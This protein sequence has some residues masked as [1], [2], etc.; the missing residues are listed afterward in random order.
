MG[1]LLGG[2][3]NK[4]YGILGVY[5]GVLLF[6]VHVAHAGP[7]QSRITTHTL[8]S[9]PLC[10]SWII[11]LEYIYICIALYISLNTDCYRVPR[12]M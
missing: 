8:G 11:F 3:H 6:R 7:H 5:I 10:N 1:T 12:P 4:D 2:P 9:A